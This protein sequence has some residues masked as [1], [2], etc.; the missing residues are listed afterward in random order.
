MVMGKLVKEYARYWRSACECECKKPS[1]ILITRKGIQT[2]K[3]YNG[4]K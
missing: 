4:H 3:D 2:Q 1:S